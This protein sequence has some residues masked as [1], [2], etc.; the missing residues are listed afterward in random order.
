MDLGKRI[1][2]ALSKAIREGVTPGAVVAVGRMEKEKFQLVNIS[3]C[4][5]TA[6]FDEKSAV[7]EATVFDLASLTKPLATCLLLMYMATRDMIDL[8]ESTLADLLPAVDVP[9][10]KRGIRLRQILCHSSGLP[11]HRPYFVEA[12][13]IAPARRKIWLLEKLLAEKLTYTPGKS[14][15]YS[16]L[17][18]MLLGMAIEQRT[19][20]DLAGAYQKYILEPLDLSSS[21]GFSAAM[22]AGDQICSGIA[23]TEVCPWTKRMLQ[24]T[25]HDD[26]CRAIGGVAG[27][28]GLFGRAGAVAAICGML[29]GVWRGCLQTPLVS[30]EVLKKFFKRQPGSTWALGFDTPSAKGSSSGRLFSQTSVGHL[31][32]TGTSM[33]LDLEK[34]VVV[35]LL[36]NRVHPS[37][38]NEKIRNFRPFIHD[39]V[40]ENLIGG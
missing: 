32:Y 20:Q 27:H 29:V 18:F 19:G 26:N 15:V 8:D 33:W 34:G 36:T 23:A 22:L 16:D 21:L 5:N 7:T 9:R 25:V 31:G 38:R 3:A 11:A 24:G 39:M 35:V 13:A 30:R 12:L 1:K 6:T 17:G 4:G 10:E 14:V 28:A 2:P 37:R 40:M